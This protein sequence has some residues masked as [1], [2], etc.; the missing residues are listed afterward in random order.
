MK[1]KNKN[2]FHLV[3]DKKIDDV[4][5]VYFQF[6]HLKQLYRQ[7]WQKHLPKT[8]TESVADHSFGV[9]V[10]ALLL[11]D[12]YY[13]KLNLTKIVEM[14]IVHEAGEIYAGDEVRHDKQ[15]LI[16]KYKKEKIS[17]NRVFKELKQKNKYT[18]L[19]E[20]Y[21]RRDTDL[22][23][24]VKQID[25]LEMAVQAII[26]EQQYKVNLNEFFIFIKKFLKDKK[27]LEI[28]NQLIKLRNS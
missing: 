28:F 23:Q 4:I 20:E 1:T 11:A 14:I 13:P 9:M 25:Y 18:N 12:R 7:G 19:W 24:F 8:E 2:P 26:Y 21:E 5:K 16:K 17:I 6:N 15:S 3:K 10:L 27:L 22:A